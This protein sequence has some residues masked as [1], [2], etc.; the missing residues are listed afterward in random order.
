[1]TLD[2][3][4]LRRVP[5]NGLLIERARRQT[6]WDNGDPLADSSAIEDSKRA[7]ELAEEDSLWGK[8]AEIAF[9]HAFLYEELNG[10][11]WEVWDGSEYDFVLWPDNGWRRTTIEVKSRI[12][13][14]QEVTGVV[15]PDEDEWYTD[16]LD[17][18][19]QDAKADVWVQAIVSSD[20]IT[21]AG[22]AFQED[23]ANADKLYY[24][25]NNPHALPQDE[26]RPLT[27]SA[28]GGAS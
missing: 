7:E 16:M 27:A 8:A 20:Y 22:W 4:P 24:L 12:L 13:P 6:D 14:R 15:D 11:E 5:V 18:N 19:N 9:E 1:M 2:H 3:V 26:L 23:V 10:D 25:E 28:L 17:R 21:L